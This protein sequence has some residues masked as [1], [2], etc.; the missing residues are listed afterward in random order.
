MGQVLLPV[1]VAGRGC[2][3]YAGLLGFL[4]KAMRPG[5]ISI[6]V[7][8]VLCIASL[9]GCRGSSPQTEVNEVKV[10]GAR[11]P[12]SAICGV[13]DDGLAHIPPDFNSFTPP[14]RGGAYIDP[15]YGC[16]ILRL[17]DARRQFNLAVHHQY[18]SISAINQ[19]ETRVM[20]ITE[21]GQGVVVDTA[22]N[23]VVAPRDFPA[24]NSANVPWSRDAADAFYYTNRNTLYKGVIAGHTVKS[25]A[26]HTFAGE[27]NVV[28]PDQEDLSEDGDHLWLVAGGWALLYSISKGPTGDRVSI[29]AKDAACGWHKIQIMPSNKLLVTW[30]CNGPGA[31]RG[32]EVYTTSGVLDWHMFDNSIHTDVGRDLNGREIAIVGRIPDTYK[33][34]CPS[35][36]GADVITAEPPHRVSCLVDINWASTHISY[37]DSPQGWVAI[38]FFDQS[39]CP[40]YSC[41]PQHLAADWSSRWRHFY[42]EIILVKVDG[43]SVLRLAHHRSRSA[44][45]YW[46]Q[47]RAAISR[48]GHYVVLDSNMNLSGTGLNSYSDIYLIKVR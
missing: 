32:Q 31:G 22:G 3:S 21:W 29:G 24:I 35:G 19:N 30:S 34:A 28:I 23:V 44:E 5:A 26:L 42:E 14:A 45:Y 25:I 47:S 40:G 16:T 13:K 33:D 46:A 10:A 8:S 43:S 12:D 2:W 6:L 11:A 38:S 17:T 36:G 48:D 27:P 4:G 15:Q 37:R 18:A 20:L 1:L 41:F 7:S 9:T 39:S